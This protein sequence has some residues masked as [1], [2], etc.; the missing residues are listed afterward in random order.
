MG[1]C[2]MT[3]SGEE[4]VAAV[5]VVS[6][7]GLYTFVTKEEYVVVN[8]IIA[9]PFAVNHV[10]ANLFYNMHRFVHALVP[11]ALK[12]PFLHSSNEVRQ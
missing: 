12:L 11:S 8:G 9:S 6:G 1:D 3:V 5:G 4:R 10:M 2:I 7:Q